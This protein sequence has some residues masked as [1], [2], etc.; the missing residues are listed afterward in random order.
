MAIYR[1]TQIA[2]HRDIHWIKR[3][4]Q[5]GMGT[6]CENSGAERRL[7]SS[8]GCAYSNTQISKFKFIFIMYSNKACLL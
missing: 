7:T 1:Q 2:E 8:E 4:R 6:D 5:T 3:D